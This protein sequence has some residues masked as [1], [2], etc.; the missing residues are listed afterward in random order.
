MSTDQTGPATQLVDPRA[1]RF[2]AAITSVVLAL[3]LV[4]WGVAPVLAVALLVVQ[5]LAFG[6][7]A[8][9]GGRYQPYAAAYRRFV[10]PLLGPPSELEDSRPPRFA[11]KVGLAFALGGL[12]GAGL[13]LAGISGGLVLFYSAL[14]FALAAALLNAVFDFCLGCEIYLFTKRRFHR[15]AP[16]AG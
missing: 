1:P 3:V 5:T 16:A 13:A 8:V 7:G 10:R 12:L 15:S 6:A 11:Q 2:G 9:L 14:A 4:L